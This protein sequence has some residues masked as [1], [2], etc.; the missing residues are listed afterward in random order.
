MA[1]S[2]LWS[3]PAQTIPVDLPTRFT[4][5]EAQ[6]GELQHPHPLWR[7]VTPRFGRR[8]P[9]LGLRSRFLGHRTTSA[10]CLAS[11]SW[12]LPTTSPRSP[13][14]QFLRRE[15]PVPILHS[16]HQKMTQRSARASSY[17]LHQ[18]SAMKAVWQNL[19]RITTY[20]LN[21]MRPLAHLRSPQLNIWSKS[22]LTPLSRL[23]LSKNHRRYHYDLSKSI[24]PLLDHRQI[25]KS[26]SVKTLELSQHHPPFW[27]Q[28]QPI[29]QRRRQINNTELRPQSTME[30]GH[31]DP[32][33]PR[34]PCTPVKPFNHHNLDLLAHKLR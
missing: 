20:G 11:V 17:Q 15:R 10:R 34:T 4:V 30:V 12:Q 25:G 16:R 21:L 23:G 14:I 3:A 26:I 24:C 31:L 7:M 5:Q 9:T 28:F 1:A 22:C 2:R 29:P 13:L 33:S 19:R 32:E 8:S 6:K 27:G 18:C